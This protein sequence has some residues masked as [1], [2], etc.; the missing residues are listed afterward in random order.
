MTSVCIGYHLCKK[1]K[2]NE[3]STRYQIRGLPVYIYIDDV[4]IENTHHTIHTLL[5]AY[6]IVNYVIYEKKYEELEKTINLYLGHLENLMNKWHL[7][8]TPYKCLYTIFIKNKGINN[9]TGFD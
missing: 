6:D 4:P 7:S 1:F 9:E 5:F 8:L 3:G 2:K